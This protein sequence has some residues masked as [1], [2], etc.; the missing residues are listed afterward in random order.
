MRI[1]I[2]DRFPHDAGPDAA[3]PE[4]TLRTTDVENSNNI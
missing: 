2:S 4:T 1:C 3:S